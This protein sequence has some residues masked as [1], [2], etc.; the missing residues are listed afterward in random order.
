MAHGIHS[1]TGTLLNATGK[2]PAI[3]LF[4]V[5]NVCDNEIFKSDF[6]G[7]VISENIFLINYYCEL[8][9]IENSNLSN[10]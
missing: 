4:H 3:P 6:S 5:T 9:K 8:F 2:E 7:I 1:D 10:Y